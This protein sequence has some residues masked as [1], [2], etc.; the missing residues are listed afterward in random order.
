MTI[1]PTLA[2]KLARAA[3]EL[4]DTVGDPTGGAIS[5]NPKRPTQKKSTAS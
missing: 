3:V 1:K 2:R 4:N 5:A